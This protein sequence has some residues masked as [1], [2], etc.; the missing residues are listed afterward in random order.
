MNIKI[1]ICGDWSEVKV[2]DWSNAVRAEYTYSNMDK[3]DLIKL[4]KFKKEPTM[5]QLKELLGKAVPKESGLSKGC[6]IV[7]S[8]W[9]DD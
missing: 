8:W 7:D 4:L 5:K 2:S 3:K 1:E 6:D 9:S